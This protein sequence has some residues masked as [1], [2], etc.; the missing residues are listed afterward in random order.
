MKQGSVAF[1]RNEIHEWKCSR[2]SLSFDRWCKARGINADDMP[3]PLDAPPERTKHEPTAYELK[4]E[5]ARIRRLKAIRRA[6]RKAK[7]KGN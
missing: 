7:L 4:M 1:W 5:K 2:S 3:R 6:E